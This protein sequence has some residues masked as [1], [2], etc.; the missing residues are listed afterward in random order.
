[1]N[2]DSQLHSIAAQGP[3]GRLSIIAIMYIQPL[4]HSFVTHSRCSAPAQRPIRRPS[5]IARDTLQAL[6]T[7][8]LT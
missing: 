8:D 6:Y 1:V 7:Q 4:S 2:Y 3:M 5:A